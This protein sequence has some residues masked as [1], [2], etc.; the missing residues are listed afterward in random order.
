[1]A[2][3]GLGSITGGRSPLKRGCGEIADPWEM[4]S[5]AKGLREEG[6]LSSLSTQSWLSL[7]PHCGAPLGASGISCCLRVFSLLFNVSL[8]L[9]WGDQ[10]SCFAHDCPDFSTETLESWEDSQPWANHEGWSPEAA[11]T[12]MERDEQWGLQLLDGYLVFSPAG[13]YMCCVTSSSQ[14]SS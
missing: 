5:E 1:M 11:D 4:C 13:P 14:P 10:L 6:L 12:P 7:H 3:V 8:S 9:R 2:S